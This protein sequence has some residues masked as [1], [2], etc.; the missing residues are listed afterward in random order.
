MCT[1]VYFADS[2]GTQ[3]HDIM[4]TFCSNINAY[5]TSVAL[6]S[7]PSTSEIQIG[8]YHVQVTTW[9]DP[10]D[11]A[12]DVQLLADSGRRLLRSANYRTLLLVLS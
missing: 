3:K 1:G 11:L 7:S 2:A 12:D 5:H 9:S 10:Q 6:A 4:H 8:L